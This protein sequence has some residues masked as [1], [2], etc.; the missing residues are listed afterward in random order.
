MTSRDPI[1]RSEHEEALESA[2]R[3]H[4]TVTA[5]FDRPFESLGYQAE[6]TYTPSAN[7]TVFAEE[8]VWSTIGEATGLKPAVKQP[9]SVKLGYD[10]KK[11]RIV[12]TSVEAPVASPSLQE[13]LVLQRIET[14]EYLLLHRADNESDLKLF[15]TQSDE[16][17]KEVFHR[18]SAAAFSEGYVDA[19]LIG[20]GYMAPE[21]FTTPDDLQA[22]VAETL[23]TAT[24]WHRKETIYLPI[25]DVTSV[26]LER[27]S[28][29]QPSTQFEESNEEYVKEIDGNITAI[30]E[31]H[32]PDSR[33]Q[34][35]IKFAY[36]DHF[37]SMPEVTTRK[38]VRAFDDEV[39]ANYGP[40]AYQILD[41]QPVELTPVQ[42]DELAE[43]LTMLF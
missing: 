40:D 39:I 22:H 2:K 5:P 8:G 13:K 41:S 34:L 19:L 6:F 31:Y 20:A 28:S 7:D 11:E 16:F 21:I 1:P 3:L 42:M 35:V 4:D 17:E 18:N 10:P 14:G 38:V 43:E 32:N 23:D 29:V 12:T 27:V 36:S 15:A 33:G 37:V 30:V 25:D 24:K 26:T 9:W